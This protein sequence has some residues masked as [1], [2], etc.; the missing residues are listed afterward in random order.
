MGDMLNAGAHG[1]YGLVVGTTPRMPKII[2]IGNYLA[3]LAEL[4]KLP[5]MFRNVIA[6]SVEEF[7]SLFP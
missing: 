3:L 6:L 4:E 1:L 5:P 2:R 7:E